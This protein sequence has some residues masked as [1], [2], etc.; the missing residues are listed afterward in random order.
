M[1]YFARRALQSLFLL[2]GVSVLAFLLVQLAPGEFWDEMRLNPRISES[3]ITALRSR[4]GLDQPVAVK[5]LRWMRSVVHGDWGYSFAYNCPAAPL[6]FVR[7]RNTLLLTGTATLFAWLIAIPLG[8]WSVGRRSRFHGALLSFTTSSL[9]A[10]PDLVLA[11]AVLLFAVRT[12]YFPTG[13]MVSTGFSEIGAFGKAKD[14]GSHLFLPAFCLIVGVLPILVSHVRSA[15]AEVWKSPFIA[16]ARG[17]GIPRQRLLFRH[18]LPAAANP[19]ISLFGFSIGALLSSSLL[20]EVVLSWPGLGQL[21]LEAILQ[22]DLYLVIGATMLSTF[23]LIAGNLLA[24]TL[25]YMSDPRIV[26]E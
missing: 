9:L 11:L 1:R 15:M 22:R 14:L 18:A 10:I 2:A 17:F 4:Y 19:L 7:A 5:Y 3:T 13:G 26:A 20:V 23:L 25:L 8:A 24:D 6:L 16:A 21:L 12:G